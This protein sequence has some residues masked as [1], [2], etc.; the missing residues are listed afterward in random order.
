MVI[1]VILNLVGFVCR[2]SMFLIFRRKRRFDVQIQPSR[3]LMVRI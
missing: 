1:F 3:I 2:F